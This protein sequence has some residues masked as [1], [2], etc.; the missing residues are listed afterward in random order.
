[1]YRVRIIGQT[2]AADVR[3]DTDDQNQAVELALKAAEEDDSP[4]AKDY[5]RIY[6]ENLETGESVDIYP[7]AV[8]MANN[9]RADV[10]R[11]TTDASFVDILDVAEEEG[12][13]EDVLPE[14]E[15]A[16]HAAAVDDDAV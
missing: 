11:D 4:A 2:T 16:V 6:V 12:H 3:V 13:L 1:M 7:D 5:E 8:K 15:V 10:G 9:L 14:P